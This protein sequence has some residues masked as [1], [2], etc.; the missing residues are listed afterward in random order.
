[1]IAPDAG[2]RRRRRRS[3]ARALARRPS[4]S[5]FPSR[6]PASSALGPW[7]FLGELLVDVGTPTSRRPQACAARP[8]RRRPT[9]DRSRVDANRCISYTIESRGAIARAACE[10][11]PWAFG[12]DVPGVSLGA[13]GPISRR[14]SARTP[15]SRPAGCGARAR[16]RPLASAARGFAAN[17]RARGPGA[18]RAIA[19]G[20]C[21]RN[22]ALLEALT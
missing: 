15:P 14:A 1:M 17:D 18:Q 21:L 16:S 19:L 13:R 7:F 12:C 2:A 5:G 22:A 3:A 11:R 8:A 4:R 10:H 9:R 6:Q 20:T